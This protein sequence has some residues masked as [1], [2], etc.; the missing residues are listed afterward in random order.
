MAYQIKLLDSTTY[1]VVRTDIVKDH[2]EIEMVGKTAEEAQTIFNNPGNLGKIVLI[3]EGEEFGQL[4]NWTQYGGIYLNGE[5]VTALLTQPIDD[6]ETRITNAEVVSAEAKSTA[7]EAITVANSA[8]STVEGISGTAQEA[9]QTADSAKADAQVALVAF[10]FAKANAQMLD[11]NTAL[12]FK[13]LY[14][15]WQ[16]LVDAGFKAEEIGYK[17]THNEVLYKTAQANFTFQQQWEPGTEGTQSIYTRIDESHAG[18]KEDP[19]PYEKN[20]ELFEGKYYTQNDVLYLCIRDS[21]IAMQYDLAD[22]V[23][24]KYV[25]VVSE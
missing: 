19:I 20:M 13:S 7:E 25:E 9:K 2:L 4:D 5:N 17:F 6:T 21:G 3:Q 16:T 11:N 18:T 22:L 12:K 23:T 1:D 8:K 15:S 24:S 14:E 10:M